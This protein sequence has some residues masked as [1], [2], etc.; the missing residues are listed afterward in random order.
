[1]LYSSAEFASPYL[2]KEVKSNGFAIVSYVALDHSTEDQTQ[3]LCQGLF[4][5]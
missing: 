4:G 1:M 5:C 2:S 3:S